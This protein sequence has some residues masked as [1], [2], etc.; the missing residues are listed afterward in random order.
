MRCC[1]HAQH[2]STLMRESVC[3]PTKLASSCDSLAHACAHAVQ[4][5]R[6]SPTPSFLDTSSSASLLITRPPQHQVRST[7]IAFIATPF[8]PLHHS[9][10]T[11]SLSAGPLPCRIF[12]GHFS[13]SLFIHVHLLNAMTRSL[14]PRDDACFVPTFTPSHFK[15]THHIARDSDPKSISFT[16]PCSSSHA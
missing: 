1:K 11:P 8:S 10:L 14:A 16:N 6:S 4:A 13:P 15:P 7:T 12:H 2:N 5:R 9:S 3:S